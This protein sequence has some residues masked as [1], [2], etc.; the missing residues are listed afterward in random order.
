NLACL[1]LSG[2]NSD[3]TLGLKAVKENGGIALVQNPSSAV[4]NFMPQ[5]ALDHVSVDAVLDPSQMANYINKM[6]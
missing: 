1:L 4:V 5:Y 6:A 2:A 3:G